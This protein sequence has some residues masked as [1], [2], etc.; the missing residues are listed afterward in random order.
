MNLRFRVVTVL[1]VVAAGMAGCS[2]PASPISAATSASASASAAPTF[3]PIKT[4]ECSSIPA[5][6]SI[7]NGDKPDTAISH[8]KV[9]CGEPF[10]EYVDFTYLG[11]T[12]QCTRPCDQNFRAKPYFDAEKVKVLNGDPG[13]WRPVEGKDRLKVVCQV[14]SDLKLSGGT[15][16]DVNKTRSNVW[17]KIADN[18]IEDGGIGWINDIWMGNAGF[19]GKA[20]PAGDHYTP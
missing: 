15:L 14:A 16:Q 17:N 9:I 12:S 8:T 10:E 6:G 3:T 20:C 5:S 19:R 1:A 4:A 13:E 2:Q 7:D 18:R 11:P